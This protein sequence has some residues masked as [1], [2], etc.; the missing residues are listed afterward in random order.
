MQS[1]GAK[2]TPQSYAL[3]KTIKTT[4]TPKKKGA[5]PV[6]TTKHTLLGQAETKAE[7]LKKYGGK[8]PE[9]GEVLEVPPHSMVVRCAATSGCLGAAAAS[10]T[11]TYY[12]LMDYYPDGKPAGPA[13]CRR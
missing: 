8:V 4:T 3:F 10:P 6:T 11:G 9:N 1:T 13:R 12:Y 5:K 7:L 2:G